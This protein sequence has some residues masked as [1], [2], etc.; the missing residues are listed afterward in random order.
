[1]IAVNHLIKNN[2]LETKKDYRLFL[3]KQRDAIPLQRRQ[4]A[5]VTANSSLRMLSEPYKMVLSYASFKSEIN[6]WSLNRMLADRQALVLP[7]ITNNTLSL[8]HVT[9]L[10]LLKP[11]QWGILEPD[12]QLCPEVATSSITL[13]LVPGLGFDL[14]S[15]HRIGYGKG[16]YDRLLPTLSDHCLTWGVG[17]QEQASSLPIEPH[18]IPLSQILLF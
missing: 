6:L 17:F 3:H 1:M 2:S 16:H 12:P 9:D 8:F 11:N 14:T 7:R 10:S 4:Q 15:H 5:S 13:S 18:D